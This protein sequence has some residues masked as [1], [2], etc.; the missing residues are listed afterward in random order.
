MA[1]LFGCLDVVALF[2]KVFGDAFV[3]KTVDVLVAV[4]FVECIA[5]DPLD[6]GPL[7]EFVWFDDG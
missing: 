7:L 1:N 5:D 3:E 2:T 4:G 6:L